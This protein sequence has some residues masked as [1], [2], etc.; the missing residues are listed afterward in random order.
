MGN[1]WL[2]GFA[3]GDLDGNPSAGD[4]DIFL[5]KFKVDLED[6]RRRMAHIYIMYIYIYICVCVT[7][8]SIYIDIYIYIQEYILTVQTWEL[9]IGFASLL[10]WATINL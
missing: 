3:E 1:A 10:R 9:L 6:L 2:A 8:S 4:A 7:C 5:A